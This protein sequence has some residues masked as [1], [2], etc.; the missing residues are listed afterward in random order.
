MPR[1]DPTESQ[2]ALKDRVQEAIKDTFP[3]EGQKH[4]LRLKDIEVT[5]E[6][7]IGDVR[8]QKETKLKGRTFG[9]D[10]KAR[11]EL[12][13]KESGKVI[14]AQNRKIATLP[15]ITRRYSYLVNGSEYQ[16]DNLWT[17]K[18]G[19]YTRIKQ[20]GELESQVNVKGG[21]F[22]VKFDPT[23]RRFNIRHGG[24]NPPLY[25]VMKALGVDDDTLERTW[26]KE[27]LEANRKAAKDPQKSAIEFAKRLLPPGQAVSTAEEASSIIRANFEAAEMKPEVTARTLG[28]PIDRIT[29]DAML[30]TS[31]RLL[32]VSRG[33]QPPD[34]RDALMF[35]E[36]RSTED[37]VGDRVRDQSKIV[38]R[39]VH[40]NLDRREKIG[41][42]VGPDLFNR[43][44]RT[45]FTKSTLSN[46]AEQT[47]PLSMIEAHQKTTIMG[48]EGGI[49]SAHRVIDEAKLVNPSHFGFL[50]PLHTPESEKTGVSLHTTLGLK[51]DGRDV[52]IPMYNLKTK[53]M[54]RVTPS[55]VFDNTVV[56]P[57]EVEWKGGKPVPKRAKVK[58]S[59]KGN[60]VGDTAFKD[61]D[62]VMPASGQVFSVAMNM[63]PF[64]GNNSQNRATMAGRHQEQA[65]SLKYRQAPQVQ[66][67]AGAGKTYDELV[68]GFTAQTAPVSGTVKSVRK[69]RIIIEEKGG[70]KHDIPIYDNYPLNEK[71]GLLDS[72]PKVKSGQI[73]KKG[74]LIAD[75]SFTKDG[76]Y[77]PGT[78][79]RVAYVPARGYNVEDGIVI[80]ETAAMKL[81]SEHMYKKKL[82]SREGQLLG[83]DKFVAYY[84]EHMT[85]SQKEKLDDDGVIRIGQKVEPGDTLVAALSPRLVKKDDIDLGLIH[86]SLVKPY[87]DKSV[88]WEEDRVG[89]VVGITRRPKGVEVHVRSE[90][91]AVIGDKIVSRHAN[92][93]IITCHDHTTFCLTDSG[94]KLFA[95]LTYKD[96]VCTLNPDTHEIE[97]CKPTRIIAEP[98]DGK[99]YDLKGRRVRL[100]TTPNHRHYVRNAHAGSAY[101]FETSETVFG[102][103]R[104][105]LRTGKWVGRELYEVVIPGR[106]RKKNQHHRFSD[107]A[108]Y[109]ADTFLEFFGYW[110]TEG[111]IGQGKI[112]VDQSEKAN[113]ETYAAIVDC[114]YRLGYEPWTY[115]TS[116]GFSD[117]RLAHWLE[118]FGKAKDKFIPREFLEASSRQL[119]IMAEAALS[120]D[121]M[122]WEDTRHNHTRVEF[123]TSSSKLSDD[124]QELALKLG[125]SA[126]IREPKSGEYVVRLSLINEAYVY[127]DR[128]RPQR[129][130]WIDYSGIV[131]CVDVPNHVV[132][133]R[134]EGTPVWSG[135]SILPDSEMPRTEDGN[136]I[137]VLHNPMGVPGRMNVGQILETAA[138]KISTKTGRPF[139]VK[140]FELDDAVGHIKGEL[141]KHGLTDKEVLIDPKTGKKIPPVLVGNQYTLKLH[142]QVDDK[143]SVRSRDAYDRNL[144]PKSGLPHGGQAVGSLE[145]YGLLAHGAKHNIREMA[146]YKCLTW[147]TLVQTDHGP[148]PIGKIVNQ[149]LDVEV[150]TA[151]GDE[152]VY[153]KIKNHWKRGID[154]TPLVEVSTYG[155]GADGVFK[156]RKIRCTHEHEFFAA[157][158]HKKFARDLEGE[159][160]FAPG[161][162]PSQA[163]LDVLVGSLLGDGSLQVH[164]GEFPAFSE[165]HS[166]RQR[167]YLQFKADMLGEFSRTD[168]LE[169]NAGH[170]GFNVGQQ[171]VQWGTLAQPAFSAI[172]KEFYCG[173]KVVPRNIEEMLNPLALAV[174]FQDDGSLTA[175]KREGRRYLSYTVRLHTGSFDAEDRSILKSALKDR[176]GF[177][178]V[179]CKN[180][181]SFD[182]RLASGIDEI[183][184][185]IA[186]VVPFVHPSM[187]YKVGDVNCGQALEDL[188]SCG[189]EPAL[190]RVP[191][192]SVR[193]FRSS[194]WEGLYLYNLEIEGTHRYF[195]NGVLVGNSD[196]A[197]G[198][199]ND[200]LWGALQAGELLP[201]PKTT[202]AYKKFTSYL[203]GLGVNVDKDGNSLIL[204]PMT[205]KQTLSLSN[206]VIK[207][208][209]KM[210]KMRT[211]EPEKGGLF[212]PKITGGEGGTKWSHIQLKEAMPNP[213]FESAIRF[214]TGI[215][216]PQFDRI[217][218][219]EEGV[220]PDGSI[221]GP[222]I[223]GAQ[224]GPSAVGRL[225]ENVEV[226]TEL[227]KEKERIGGLRGQQLNETNKRIKYLQALDRIGATPKEAYMTKLVPV[228]PPIM[229]PLSVMDDGNIQFEDI[230]HIYKQVAL[231]NQK[232]AQMHR[233]TPDE[234]KAPLRSELYDELKSL[235][236]TGGQLNRTYP[237]IL[238]TIAGT[239][240]KT[241]FFQDKLVKRKQDLSMRSTI[242]PEPNLNLDEAG[243]PRKAA[244]ELYKPFVVRELRQTFGMHPLEAQRSIQEDRSIAKTAL[245]QVV[246]DRPLILKRDPVLHRYGIQAF[247]PRLIEGKAI[248]IHPLVT[249]GFNADFDGDA[250]AA[251]VPITREAVEEAR[252]MMPS[253][254]LFSP[255][256]GKAAYTPIKEMQVGLFGLTE[257]GK[258]TNK[259]FK[260]EDDLEKAV[261][262]G[263]TGVNDV[264]DVKG[265][266]TT[267]GRLRVLSALP[268]ELQVKHRKRILTDL[269]Y[270]FTKKDQSSIFNEMAKVDP[271]GYMQQIDKMKDLGNEQAFMSGFS[272]GLDDLKV[273]KDLRD[274]FLRKAELR[275]RKLDPTDKKDA[276]KF[277][278]EYEVALL[279]IEDA[280]KERAKGVHNNLDRLEVAAGIKGNAYRQLSAAPVL[281]TDAQGRVV[282]SPVNKSYSEGLDVASYWASMSGGRKGII[283]K[284]Q[285]VA[286]PG[287][288]SKL[289]MN[290]TMN[291]LIQGD[292]CGTDRGIA[293]STDEPDV[294]GRYSQ[295]D[296]KL[297]D[298]RSVPRGTVITPGVMSD[299]RN[300]RISRVVVRSPM[301]CNHSK[302]VCPKCYGINEQGQ[303][304]DQG[305]NIGVIA[306][307]SLGERGVQLSLR[308]FHSG[309]VHDP[310]GAA[311]SDRGLDRAKDLLNLPQTLKGSATLSQVNGKVSAVDEDPAGGWNVKIEGKRHYVPAGRD[312]V[313]KPGSK[314]KKG[315]PISSGPINPH[316]M[317]P[318]T[319]I[320]PV[321]NHLAEELNNIYSTEGIR[322]RNTE[323]VVRSMSDVTRVK[324]PG[325]HPDYIRGDFTNTS[326]V[327][328][329]NKTQLK[330]KKPIKHEPILK[331]VKKIP[332][333]VMEDW[334]ARLNQEELK[335]TVIEGA[336]RG[337]KSDIHSTHP[338]PG[339]VFGAEFG[340]GEKGGY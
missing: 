171:M 124:Y 112:H 288:L 323:V 64:L 238:D 70:K 305:T 12:V 232:L 53:K 179:D 198:G 114:L 157:D 264:V 318:L 139:L 76:I 313:V 48:D 133:V 34:D 18:P 276:L 104:V 24:A 269:D 248:K 327:Q 115:P 209:G 4:I 46:V 94:W 65:V 20:N 79:L 195:A 105:H 121:G 58:A 253:N 111:C 324:D 170:E 68:G 266:K 226:K 279:G 289:M 30:R 45:F 320:E 250:M 57:D 218:S 13:D 294:I 17:L 62:Y 84:P 244:M 60:D 117:P 273:H 35:K 36:L 91:P 118:Q 52:T 210:V 322:R 312:L 178:F 29:P 125:V 285:S 123:F 213:I 221:V 162:R 1:L 41:D 86:K 180:N 3:F 280:V 137:E 281:F 95:D 82:S 15:Q 185:F 152:L 235:A 284:V 335:S 23:S 19:I 71:K 87:K 66:S 43:P 56:M 97:Y 304:H 297:N 153:R 130:S 306:A 231:S 134:K 207:D 272:I 50:D 196:K 135:N 206:G 220:M 155:P 136:P 283:E 252:K 257:I 241:G 132:Y 307:Q 233:L 154:D 298:G 85:V 197:Q 61:A 202:F 311:V 254:L 88:T 205:D 38:A 275:T 270:R 193:K 251:F 271:K 55:T 63:V 150:L 229:R 77:A 208:G 99:M 174:W 234:E 187:S 168:L 16:V 338:I 158:G 175:G 67:V 96:K 14:D 188:W 249:S 148:I 204:S 299:I 102:K 223:D 300:S 51:K 317:L 199:D 182:L 128:R 240:P 219:G 200:A 173:S 190:V 230:N 339:V 90:E 21:G 142:H 242:V 319:G 325:D 40:N 247:K 165:R 107:S 194:L 336:T 69:D 100:C 278:K 290:A 326:Q 177:E 332:Q 141:K 217:I 301:K 340:L 116:I 267:A 169:Y 54:E 129:E 160:L 255:A 159:E 80:S 295:A 127:N 243:I 236:G 98:Y 215:R 140:N 164:N 2:Q 89:T 172:H 302:G 6:P 191:V 75:T 186:L 26:G 59:L 37:F 329:L 151:D 293:L 101:G 227:A 245:N 93:G 144:I 315:A 5:N 72:I 113:P 8:K 9:S 28:K 10:V 120:G 7:N 211:L 189:A 333:D 201:P 262:T 44:I 246:K 27:I 163:Q 161:L 103:Q 184:R 106:P 92:K 146:T 314:A 138:S 119:S 167:E 22:H 81:T 310:K 73:V 47:N 309:G 282:T 331:G 143:M 122:E 11:L 316:D 225:L 308:K 212:D 291:Q 110:I 108:S 222:E 183:D 83:K 237:G 274:P 39:K 25:P 145:L 74:E 33:E 147:N 78:N 31:S 176:Y 216:K 268:P 192:L 296:I 330:G 109:D 239:S 334:L 337:W 321:Q 286:E 203:T 214:T 131:Y 32:G 259:R 277:V 49:K 328:Y 156:K 228:L 181:T 126:N 287:Y 149:K 256:T 42:I 260:S 265:T 261:I 258:K 303:L 292:D 263:S 224:Y 166:V